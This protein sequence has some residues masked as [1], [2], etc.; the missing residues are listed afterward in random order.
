[1]TFRTLSTELVYRARV[2]DVRRDEVQYPNGHQTTYEI[3][4]HS[5]AV[6]MVPV[7]TDDRILFVRQYRHTTGKRILE[8]P[9]GTLNKG[10]DPAACAQRELREE[11]GMAPGKLTKLA[12]FFLAPGYSTERVHVYLAR[13][14]S[15]ESLPQDED[16][17]L[18]VEPLSMEE[19]FA[20]IRR[21]EIE[22]AKTMLGLFLAREVLRNGR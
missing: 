4:V 19:A 3:V 18:E 14:L 8:I 1:M 20:A 5:G 16:E 22:E 12:E 2:F 10:E 9:A 17:D 21:G 11:I 6:A 7:D 13:D 15:P